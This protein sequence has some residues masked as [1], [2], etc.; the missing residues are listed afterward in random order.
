MPKARSKK[1]RRRNLPTSLVIPFDLKEA[2]QR[3]ASHDRRSLSNLII[4]ALEEYLVE[5]RYYPERDQ[6]F[7]L[8]S[9][10]E[11]RKILRAAQTGEAAP[12]K[13]SRQ[14]RPSGKEKRNE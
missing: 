12:D 10:P 6:I 14:S 4:L 7:D 5:R 13:A 1:T 8:P 3:A 11:I 2:A 9:R